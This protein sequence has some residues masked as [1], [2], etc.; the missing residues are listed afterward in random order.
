MAERVEKRYTVVVTKAEKGGN[1]G[2]FRKITGVKKDKRVYAG[3]T[4]A[5]A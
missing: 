3:G 5:E 1:D 4:C 2:I